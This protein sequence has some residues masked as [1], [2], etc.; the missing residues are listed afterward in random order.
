MCDSIVVDEAGWGTIIGPIFL[1]GKRE[2]SCCHSKPELLR[3]P[4]TKPFWEEL[5][6]RCDIQRHEEWIQQDGVTPHTAVG[7]LE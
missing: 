6:R 5:G 1:L 2:L 4:R 7:F 3:G